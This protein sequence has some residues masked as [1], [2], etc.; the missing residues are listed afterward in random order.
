MSKTK[1]NFREHGVLVRFTSS[2][3]GVIRKDNDATIAAESEYDAETGMVLVNKAIIDKKTPAYKDIKKVQGATGN[4]VRAMTGD[5]GDTDWR[6]ISTD[7]LAMLQSTVSPLSFA[8]DEAK[9]TLRKAYPEIVEQAKRKAGKLFDPDLIPDVEEVLEKFTF[10]FQIRPMAGADVPALNLADEQIAQMQAEMDAELEAQKQG[11]AEQ[12]HEAVRE[13]LTLASKHLKEFGD[14]ITGSKRSRSFN[15]NLIDE[16]QK[17]GALLSNLNITGDP[18][19]D[20]LSAK[21]IGQFDGV[22]A[23]DLKGRKRKGEDKRSPAQRDAEAAKLREATAAKTDDL[24]DDL[25]S[26]F[27]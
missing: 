22:T 16:V 24:L 20:A 5:M 27:G 11:L 8:F 15:D 25:A 17:I 19:L 6:F 26:V 10:N 7:G 23:D 9:E 14:E 1:F 2:G 3:W 12:S 18:K 4:V 13:I 21:I